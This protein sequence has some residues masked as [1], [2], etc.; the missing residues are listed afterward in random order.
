MIATSHL[1]RDCPLCGQLS[2]WL[3]REDG[4]AEIDCQKDGVFVLTATPEMM[5][6]FE[7]FKRSEPVTFQ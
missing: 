3:L 2:T 6:S 5:E 1:L 4:K 7:P